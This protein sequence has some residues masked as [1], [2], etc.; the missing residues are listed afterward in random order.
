MTANEA[1]GGARSFRFGV[2]S[3]PAASVRSGSSAASRPSTRD[4]QWSRRADAA[5]FWLAGVRELKALL[6]LF[7]EVGR[8]RSPLRDGDVAGQMDRIRRAGVAEREA[9]DE[10][11]VAHARPL[12]RWPSEVPCWHAQNRP[13]RTRP[14]PTEFLLR[15]L[16]IWACPLSGA[17]RHALGR[18]TCTEPGTVA[19]WL[20]YAAA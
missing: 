10:L 19:R 7:I 5:G 4:R 11:H 1:T 12:T 16:T 6:G 15:M 3:R 17:V 9:Q 20:W 18:I 8:K 2:V 14:W 13:M